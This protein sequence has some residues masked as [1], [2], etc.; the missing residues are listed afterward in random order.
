MEEEA[1]LVKFGRYENLCQLRDQGLLYMKSLQYFKKIEDEDL[2]GDKYEGVA[3]I[4]RGTSGTVTPKNNPGSPYIVRR[5]EIRWDL[6]H[7]KNINIFCMCAVRPSMG[8]FPVNKRNFRFGDHALILT[9][10]QEFIDRIS[11]Q[12]KSQNINHKANLV[13]YFNN[14]YVGEVGPFR[15]PINFA[16]QSEWRLACYS[17]HDKEL[18]DICIGNI[19]DISIVVGS[20]DVNSKL[21]DLLNISSA[22]IQLN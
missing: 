13:E 14:D 21:S 22:L 7:Y 12:L 1:T 20:T 3:E 10:P 2:R 5:W 6:P 4:K 9:K 19:K 11:S 8:S 15:K 17:G 18:N 16:Y